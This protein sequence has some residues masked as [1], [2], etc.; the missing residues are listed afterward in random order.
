M[1]KYRLIILKFFFLGGV[2]YTLNLDSRL[3][4][5]S[6]LY[7]IYHLEVMLLIQTNTPVKH[8][9]T[10]KWLAGFIMLPP[11]RDGPIIGIGISIG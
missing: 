9:Q 5:V 8:P 11:R 1:G 4:V 6:S 3:M 10:F 2:L 7:S